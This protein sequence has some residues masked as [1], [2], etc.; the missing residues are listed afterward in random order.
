M[1]NAS[2]WLQQVHRLGL[3]KQMCIW[4]DDPKTTKET[5]ETSDSKIPGMKGTFKCLSWTASSKA[6]EIQKKNLLPLWCLRHLFWASLV[7]E[8]KEAVLNA[9]MHFLKITDNKKRSASAH[10]DEIIVRC[11]HYHTFLLF[12]YET[13]KT[14]ALTWCFFHYFYFYDILAVT[15]RPWSNN[16]W[17]LLLQNGYVDW[18]RR[19]WNASV[20]CAQFHGICWFF[21]KKYQLLGLGFAACTFKILR[22][23]RILSNDPRIS[24]NSLLA[25]VFW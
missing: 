25:R 17:V 9:P 18:R 21:Q 23:N 15:A 6:I 20:N 3:T 24:R 14:W 12:E 1:S 11:C 22:M 10:H 19:H 2:I 4:F 16:R 7:R 8:E 5:K 13:D